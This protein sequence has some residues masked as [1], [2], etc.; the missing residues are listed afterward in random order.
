MVAWWHVGA[1]RCSD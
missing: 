1:W